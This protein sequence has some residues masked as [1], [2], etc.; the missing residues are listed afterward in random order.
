MTLGED[1]T[2]GSAPCRFPAEFVNEIVRLVAP[3]TTVLS[4]RAREARSFARGNSDHAALEDVCS[5]SGGRWG[6]EDDARYPA[7]RSST[8]VREPRLWPL[9]GRDAE[10]AAIAEAL[11][12]EPPMNVVISGP[13]GVGKTR[14]LREA[15]SRAQLRGRP[16]RSAAGSS[17]AAAVPLGALAPLLPGT[18]A[19][20]P[21]LLA[22]LQMATHAIAGDRAGP[23]PVLG[24]DDMHF[25][26]PLSV[27][28]M[29]QLAATG[30]V[31]LVL[32]VR[33]QPAHCDPSAH[34]WKDELA[35]RLDIQPLPRHDTER[36]VGSVLDGDVDSRTSE[37]LWRMSEGNPQY[38]REL[39]EEGLRTGQLQRWRG[40]WRWQGTVVPSQRLREIVLAQLGEFDPSEWRAMEVLATAEPLSVQ[41]LAELSSLGAVASLQRRGLMVDAATGREGEVQAAHPL[42][43]EVV[44]RRA[45]EAAMRAIRQQLAVRTA[46]GSPDEWMRRSALLLEENLPA[47]DAG[48]LTTA[49]LR[50]VAMLDHPLGERLARAGIEAGGGAGAHLALVEAAWWQGQ[51]VRSAQL[52]HEAAQLAGSDEDRARLTTVEVL[53]LF[54]G[55][56][57]TDDA[58]AALHVAAAT[59]ESTEGRAVLAATEAVLAFLRGDPR[60]AV[61]LGT[62]VLASA[63]TGIA[64]PLAA[65]AAAAGLAV[66]GRTDRALVTARAGWTALEALPAGEEL[67]FVRIA[68]AQAEV[69]ALCLSGRISELEQRT[70]ELYH[71]NLT[72]PEWAGDAVACVH[73]GWAALVAGRPGVALRWLQ[74]ALSSL[75]QR[76]PAGFLP[77]CCSLTA[78][79]H[80]LAGNPEAARE[81]LAQGGR[82]PSAATVFEPCARV[83][84]AWLAAA[85]G[86]RADAGALAI[87]AADVAAAQGQP[88]VEALLLHGAVRFGAVEE[89]CER[90]GRLSRSL[91]SPLLEVMA[92]RAG[93]TLAGAG[94]GL[95]RASQRFEEL[96]AL[97]LAA[98]AAAEAA[99]VHEGAGNRQAAVVSRLR[100]EALA[101]VCGVFDTPGL[102]VQAPPTLTSREEQV[103]RLAARGLS[104]QGIADQLVVSVRTVEAHLAHVYAKLGITGRATLRAALTSVADPGRGRGQ[105]LE[106]AR[107][108]PAPERDGTSPA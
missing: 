108:T 34:L 89:V 97:L 74:E 53:T 22:L 85:E 9:V 67:A 95:D 1:P 87:G 92:L 43:S 77:L 88:A 60:E 104:N 48:I 76:D 23:R 31:T 30:G 72:A 56:G 46:A 84:E 52:A 54:C 40:L 96:G 59:V 101:R 8:V 20:A 82:Q 7:G 47:H 26:D 13:P 42:Y 81:V 36:L 63:P 61:R 66:S 18:E 80:A 58:I 41:E 49:A 16:I 2:S 17:A 105:A 64:E 38:L 24:V 19:P 32:A 25:L 70:A 94:A 79:A 29:D 37:R 10:C 5:A 91:D 14:L 106:T 27:T 71:H 102:D 68:L 99:A 86:R 83:A 44:R 107:R 39:L 28:V 4:R 57:R 69:M 6:R 98:E 93:A 65:A 62:S 21:D 103:A 33:S 12:A 90:L 73:R 55:L 35:T 45:P 75:E 51:P 15:L 3:P 100:A 11:D 78:I 50:A